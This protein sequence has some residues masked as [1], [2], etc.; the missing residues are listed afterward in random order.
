MG[1]VLDQMKAN[2]RRYAIG[3]RQPMAEPHSQ[4]SFL[5]A[6]EPPWQGRIDLPGHHSILPSVVDFY[7][8]PER[9]TLLVGHT[10]RQEQG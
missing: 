9:L 6:R 4:G 7:A 5:V 8:I 1:V 10:R 2:V 3:A